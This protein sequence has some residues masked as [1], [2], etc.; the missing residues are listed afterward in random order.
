MLIKSKIIVWSLFIILLSMSVSCS[1]SVRFS[2]ENAGAHTYSNSNNGKARS[3]NNQ[4]ATVPIGDKFR[5]MA[6]FY[7]SEFEGRATSS[8]EIYDGDKHTGAHQSIPFGA[9]VKVK[10]LKNGKETIIIINDRGPWKKGRVLDLSRAA[11]E[12]LGMIK[13]GV[14]EVEA[15][16][17]K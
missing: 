13:D 11:A 9:K 8:G 2:S 15:E 12:S 10:N 3:S 16:V 14:V 17:V 1:S 7:G 4:S 6:S 5:G